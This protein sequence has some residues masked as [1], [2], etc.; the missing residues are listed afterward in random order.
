[1]TDESAALGAEPSVIADWLMAHIPDLSGVTG[2]VK[3]GSGQSN[4]TY[5]IDTASGPYVLRS[6]PPGKLLR[7]AHL[8]EREYRVMAAL[9]E[10][11]VPVPNMLALA[12]DA[13]SPT[14]RAFFVMEYLDGEIFWDP[15]LP[16]ISQTDRRAYY[17]EMARVL[18]ALHSVDPKAVG[19]CDY[20]KPGNYFARQTERWAEQYRASVET[21]SEAMMRIEAWLRERMPED[22]GQVALVHGDYRLDNMMFARGESRVIGL[23][24]WELSTLGHPL[25]DLAYQCFQWRLPHGGQMRGLAGKDRAALGLPTEE[26]YVAAY[27]AARGIDGVG[28]WTFYL[29]FSGFR[30]A[31]ILQGVASRAAAGNASDPKGAIYGQLVPLLE[32]MIVGM[33]D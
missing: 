16:E 11:D 29:V 31:A 25:A 27:S 33:L 1:M 5:R 17:D 23:L 22:D 12:E 7:S 32:E 26:E 9:A 18:A 10:T 20:G 2:L 19:L 28:D 15:V 24:D 8:V 6:K 30:L 4:P 14:G 3:F 21:P 13:T